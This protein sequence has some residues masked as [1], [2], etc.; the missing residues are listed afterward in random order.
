MKSDNS[1]LMAP[2]FYVVGGEKR[3][4]QMADFFGQNFKGTLSACQEKRLF[5]GFLY[6]S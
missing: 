3:C 2:A 4:G 6:G 5:G 1:N